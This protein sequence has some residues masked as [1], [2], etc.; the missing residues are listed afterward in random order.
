MSPIEIIHAAGLGID[1]NVN[2][3]EFIYL[4]E[5]LLKWMKHG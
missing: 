2:P 5:L 1:E 3:K 4:Y